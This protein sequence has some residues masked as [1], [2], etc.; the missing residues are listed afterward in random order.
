MVLWR[1]TPFYDNSDNST[2]YV[3]GE[4]ELRELVEQLDQDETTK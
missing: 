2:N 1:G 4:R 3:S